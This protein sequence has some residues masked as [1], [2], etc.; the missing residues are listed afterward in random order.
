MFKEEHVKKF[1]MGVF[2]FFMSLKSFSND[3]LNFSVT[4]VSNEVKYWV[5][6]K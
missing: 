2:L 1:I 6:E 5:Y 4:E 3:D